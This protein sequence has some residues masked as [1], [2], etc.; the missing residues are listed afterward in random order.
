MLF[1]FKQIYISKC[2]KL[3]L[4]VIESEGLEKY[5]D[6]RYLRNEMSEAMG[7]TQDEM[8]YA[9]HELMATSSPV[10]YSSS[11]ANNS[12]PPVRKRWSIAKWFLSSFGF[13]TNLAK[14]ALFSHD[15]F[16]ANRATGL[17]GIWESTSSWWIFCD[18]RSHTQKN[19]GRREGVWFV[20][21]FCRSFVI[22][23][24]PWSTTLVQWVKCYRL[25]FF[26]ELQQRFVVW[27]FF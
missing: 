14:A 6:A 15:V 21:I 2:V 3:V 17:A 1:I 24:H 22:L 10:S 26:F 23:C 11:S 18:S 16:P 20:Y 12:N 9:A 25:D 7:M 19:E 5:V 13:Y 8:D 4:K 27:V